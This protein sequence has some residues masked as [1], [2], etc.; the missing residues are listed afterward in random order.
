MRACNHSRASAPR[1]KGLVEQRIVAKHTPSIAKNQM[2][3]CCIAVIDPP[4][5]NADIDRLWKFFDSSCA[6][7]GAALVRGERRDHVLSQSALGTNDI[8]NQVLSCGLCNGD[9]KR[10]EP[11]ESFLARKV[12]SASLQRRRRARIEE[13][14]QQ[15]P[16]GRLSISSKKRRTAEA[17][18]RAFKDFDAAVEELR[19]LRGRST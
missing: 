17:I 1:R 13:W 15:A 16:P 2:R 9:E 3:R 18:A 14:M 12:S 7:C 5:S 8:H 19:A 6:Y 10:E 4:P 11:W